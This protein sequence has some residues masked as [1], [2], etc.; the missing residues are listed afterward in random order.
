MHSH[1][2]VARTTFLF[3]FGPGFADHL[4]HLSI[5][6]V[7]HFLHDIHQTAGWI[8]AASG[9]ILVRLQSGG[10]AL[11][12]ALLDQRQIG[13]FRACNGNRNETRKMLVYD[14]Q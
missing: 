5:A 7:V 8:A 4:L 13:P 10:F 3:A 2:H 12:D 11:T 1:I 6:T 14:L 9:Q